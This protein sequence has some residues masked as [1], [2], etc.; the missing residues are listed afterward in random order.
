MA[1]KYKENWERL[2]GCWDILC[3]AIN[4]VGYLRRC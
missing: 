3:F 1:G 4:F 2:D